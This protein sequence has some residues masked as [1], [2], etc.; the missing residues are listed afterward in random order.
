MLIR[1]SK[2]HSPRRGVVLLAVLMVV[3][4]MTLAAYQYSELM[5]A[6][7]KAT[8]SYTRATQARV[9]AESGVNY[10]AVLL[11]DPNAFANQLGSN[12]FNNPTV[13]Q[14]IAVGEPSNGGA[15]AYF[16]VIAPLG[17]DDTPSTQ[18]PFRFGATD[19]SGKINLNSLLQWDPSGNLAEQ[20][21]TN[22][23]IPDEVANAII[24]W[25]DPDDT[26]RSGGAESSTY[27]SQQP[28]YFAKNGPLDTLEELL[29]VQGVTW[30]LLFGTDLNRNGVLDPSEQ[31]LG[32]QLN[33]GWAAYLTVHSREQNVD[34]TGTPRIYVND[35]N[36]TNLYATLTSTLNNAEMTN[37]ILLYRLYGPSAAGAGAG[38]S[39][40]ASASATPAPTPTPTPTTGKTASPASTGGMGRGAATPAPPPAPVTRTADQLTVNDLKLS[41]NTRARSL[42]SIFELVNTQV[43][44]PAPNRQTPATIVP[45]PL[46]DQSKLGTL[47]PT[48]MDKLTTTRKAYLP[49]RIN[50]NTA[51]QAV[52]QALPGLSDPGTLSKIT[53]TRPD[54][55]ATTTPDPKFQT[56]AWLL[57][58]ANVPVATLKTLERFIAARSQVYRVQVVG[59]FANGR[60]PT[61]RVEA[62]IDTNLGRP[63]IVYF[64][65]L[66]E[67]GPGFDLSAVATGP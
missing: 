5:M 34:S 20:I 3:V 49:A 50:V 14:N 13:F 46:N 16:S 53:S 27:S 4:L 54:P 12:P 66:S 8:V 15:Q 43:M 10:A 28:P 22:L 39:G 6:E 32:G 38:G 37:F 33:L 56:P 51:P 24:D 57:T 1:S 2:A 44:I 47:L 52:L 19:E 42:S 29:L 64:R 48:L 11:S 21:L 67:L 65:D 9:S 62:V 40:A 60:G 35:A 41:S 61:S 26:P 18:Q 36:T 63:R 23:G 58:D 25:I 17:P 31:Q 55:N 59:H 30:D 45:S 7:Y